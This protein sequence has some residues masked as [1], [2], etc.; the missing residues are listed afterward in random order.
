MQSRLFESKLMYAQFSYSVRPN[1][2]ISQ[3]LPTCLAPR[4]IRGFRSA[5]SFHSCRI[6]VLQLHYY[7]RNNV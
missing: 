1:S 7:V 4:M 6:N 2:F 5:L 3:V